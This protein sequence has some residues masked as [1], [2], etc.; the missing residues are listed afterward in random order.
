M[1]KFDVEDATIHE[2]VE[3]PA[4]LH[5]ALQHLGGQIDQGYTII[6]IEIEQGI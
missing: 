5:S 1:I 6:F 3:M 4:L 2:A